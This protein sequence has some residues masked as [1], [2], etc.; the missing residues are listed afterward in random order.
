MAKHTGEK[1][2]F[3]FL[4]VSE[5]SKLINAFTEVHKVLVRVQDNCT[6]LLKY[7]PTT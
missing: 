6:G 2:Y 4:K 3:F 7:S 1:K 5:C